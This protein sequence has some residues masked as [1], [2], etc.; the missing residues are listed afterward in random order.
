[1]LD[2]SLSLCLGPGKIRGSK[3]RIDDQLDAAGIQIIQ[4]IDLGLREVQHLFDELC[5][6]T[7]GLWTA[8][9]DAVELKALLHELPSSLGRLEDHEIALL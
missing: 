4:R 7:V 2:A 5:A 6:V 3:R 8:V 1:M 9:E